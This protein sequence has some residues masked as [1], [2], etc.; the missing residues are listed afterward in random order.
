[1]KWHC[2][3]FDLDNTLYSPGNGLFDVVDKRIEQFLIERL[4]MDREE[5]RCFRIRAFAR[6][7]AT[8]RALRIYYPNID[9]MD[10]LLYCHDIPLERFISPNPGLRTMLNDL[11]L[12]LWI[13]TNSDRLHTERVLKRLG[14]HDLFEKWITIETMDFIPK[15]LPEAFFTLMQFL[16]YLPS[17]VVFID[18]MIQN[19]LMARR[20]GFQA[21]WRTSSRVSHID[22]NPHFSRTSP[23]PFIENLL[24]LPTLLSIL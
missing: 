1:M 15:P 13:F 7:G 16:P 5:A 18:D 8:L 19:V 12:P 11:G 23:A 22:S 4:H 10:Y 6:F 24:D 2:L 9:P 14:I 20:F 21:V 3:L 17:R